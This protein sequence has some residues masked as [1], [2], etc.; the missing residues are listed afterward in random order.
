MSRLAGQQRFEEAATTRDRLSALLG[1]IR[2]TQLFAALAEV[3]RAEVTH[4]DTTWIVADG[5]LVDT[6]T[7]TTLTAAL[8]A[9]S[10]GTIEHGRPVSRDHADEALC[11][12]KF[13][14]QHALRLT[15][16]C[17]GVWRFPIVQTE[18]IP[19]LERAA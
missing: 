4:G 8:P 10:L 3:G 18:A 13:F 15:V 1:A 7:V 9:A 14:D 12:A 17:D 2:R 11:L 19:P 16:T 5:A 6:R